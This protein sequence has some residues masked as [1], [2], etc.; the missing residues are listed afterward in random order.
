MTSNR[1]VSSITRRKFLAMA[2]ALGASAAW[3]TRRARASSM[4][5]R[6]RRELYPE[7]V[8]SGD[9]LPDS[10]ILWTRHPAPYAPSVKLTVEVARSEERRVGKECW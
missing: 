5:W 2:G 6:E 7:G 10:V 1:T 4:D 9:P 8:A 3:A